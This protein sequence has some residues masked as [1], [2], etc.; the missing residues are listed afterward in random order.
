MYKAACDDNAGGCFIHAPPLGPP[1]AADI[2]RG[3]DAKPCWKFWKARGVRPSLAR[4]LQAGLDFTD[5]DWKR[6]AA[7]EKF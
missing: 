2:D 6:F 7:T 3:L 4:R 1:W 5:K